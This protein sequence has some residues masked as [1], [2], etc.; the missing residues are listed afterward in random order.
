ML[1]T[2]QKGV[3]RYR[4]TDAYTV[5]APPSRALPHIVPRASLRR[6]ILI[7]LTGHRFSFA[8]CVEAKRKCTAVE[9]SL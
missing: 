7:I 3:E 5:F 6:L 8:T 1:K 2:F 4:H 9:A